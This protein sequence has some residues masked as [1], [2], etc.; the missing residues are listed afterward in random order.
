MYG[1]TRAS[2]TLIAAGVA[3]L[4]VWIATSWMESTLGCTCAGVA[5]T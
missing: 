2:V 1:L 5:A 3:G 4:L